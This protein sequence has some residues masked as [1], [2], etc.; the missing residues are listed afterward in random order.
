MTTKVQSPTPFSR[1][2][3]IGI[4][5]SSSPSPNR[6]NNA[7]EKV[8]GNEDNWYI[9]YNGPYEAP[10][11]PYVKPKERDSWGD[12]VYGEDDDDDDR[13]AKEMNTQHE[14]MR[15]NGW[16]TDAAGERTGRPRAKT[17]SAV[18]TS[19]WADTNRADARNRQPFPS[20]IS[21][22][23]SG[24]VGESPSP[25][26]SRDTSTVKRSSFANI[27]NFSSSKKLQSTRPLR[28]SPRQPPGRSRPS[29]RNS[30]HTDDEE[31]YNSYY[32]TLVH[33]PLRNQFVVDTVQRSSE[34]PPSSH[35]LFERPATASPTHHPYAYQFPTDDDDNL[36]HTA[37]LVSTNSNDSDPFRSQPMRPS[38]STGPTVPSSNFLR[39]ASARHSLK[40]SISSPDL[41]NSR[42]S[43]APSQSKPSSSMKSRDR[44]LSPETWCDALFLPRPRFKVKEDGSINYGKRVVSP[45]G[46]PVVTSFTPADMMSRVVAHSRSMVDL[47]PR[48]DPGPSTYIPRDLLLSNSARAPR[49]K[50]FALDDLALPSPVP[51]LS[52]VLEEGQ[53]L[54]HQRKKWQMQAQGSFQNRRTRSFSRARTKSQGAKQKHPHMD[55]LAARSFAGNQEPIPIIKRSPTE[56]RFA[57]SKSTHTHSTS[58]SKTLSNTKTHSRTH[59]RNDSWG[60]TAMKVATGVLCNVGDPSPAEE[61]R[62]GFEDALHADGTRVIRFEDPSMAAL[63]PVLLLRNTPSQASSGS[64]VRMG[65]ALSTPP[66]D[67]RESL[68]LPSHPYAQGGMYTYNGP[69]PAVHADFAGPHLSA[70]DTPEQDADVSRHRLPPRVKAHPYALY[71]DRDPVEQKDL[72]PR[73]VVDREIPTPLKM[74]AQIDDGEVREVRP[75]DIH[76]SPYMSEAGT[77]V[78][79]PAR[80]SGFIYD[81]VGVGEA[82][83]N[84]V[85]SRDSG[86]EAGD[87][88]PYSSHLHRQPVDYDA[89]RP[90]YRQMAD[91]SGNAAL[92]SKGD[93]PIS[94]SSVNINGTPPLPLSRPSPSSKN[95]S[96]GTASNDRT[97]DTSSSQ[98]SP[99]PLGN[100]DDLEN[101]RDLFY[102]PNL[103]RKTST[104]SQLT[105]LARQL[106]QEF[107]ELNHSAER[108]ISGG[109]HISSGSERSTVHRDGAIQFVFSDIPEGSSGARV[110]S[111]RGSIPP[112][113]PSISIP[114]DVEASSVLEKSPDE[115]ESDELFRLGHVEHLATPPAVASTHRTSFIGQFVPGNRLSEHEDED[116]TIT[117]SRARSTSL[118]PPSADPSRTSYTT[119]STYSRM[120]NLSDFPVP[121]VSHGATRGHISL[122]SSYFEP[123]DPQRSSVDRRLTFGGDA[124]IDELLD[125]LN[126]G[127]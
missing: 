50:S 42:R 103:S 43:P 105:T 62:A 109:T 106:S 92:A 82:L 122:V 123:S 98:A 96:D 70:I 46:S 83:A 33:S 6:R 11:Q 40:N 26:T 81:M 75:D 78:R 95:N 72:S 77:P 85:R 86:F 45:P 111:Q 21:I 118:Q 32:S 10:R 80:N 117:Q 30:G 66:I 44:W 104:R 88:H 53:I 71:A 31:Y 52:R 100:A 119:N 87:E 64:D 74:W 115:E 9:P 84:A 73:V 101:F 34:D 17:T 126:H 61:K 76:Y 18:S 37:P 36:P 59:S 48:Q 121:P 20:Y 69:S 114:E 47:Q 25:R 108:H 89:T 65:I 4:F 57:H 94:S 12:S 116:I 63:D 22:D 5:K 29:P 16:Y 39:P 99:R 112:F 23:A 124:E 125:H 120:S 41:R 35:T 15:T 113:H 19:G 14:D 54:E 27:F 107:E 93:S 13:H 2:S 55:F 7:S 110:L 127:R 67:D 90:L 49:P 58:L 8:S 56:S 28:L 91:K 79:S 1:F 102:R 97:P 60:K 38:Q 51:S 68:Q 3:R 24:G